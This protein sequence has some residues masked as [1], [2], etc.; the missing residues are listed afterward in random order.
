[1][2]TN[3]K[4]GYNGRFGN[5]LFQFASL[6]GIGNKMGFDVVIPKRN[7]TNVIKQRTMDGKE[8][9]AKFDLLDCFDIDSKYFSDNIFV[10]SV[11]TESHFHFD[12]KMFNIN[13]FTALDGYFQ[14]DKYFK[15]CREELLEI[16]KFR[17]DILE[18]SKSLLPKNEGKEL[19]SIHI[20]RGDYTTPNQ[21]HP[22]LGEDYINNALEYFRD[23]KYHFVVFSD[24]LDWCKRT[25][26]N[27]SDFTFF[28]SGSPYIDFCV[29][30]LCD[31]NI[32]TNSSFSW[33]A[34]YL[35]KIDGKKVIAPKKWFGPG[36]ANYIT[37]D[38]YP[39]WMI[40]VD[41]E[42]KK[43]LFEINIL[44]IC[45]GKY[46]SFFEGFYNSCEKYFLPNYK[47]NYF[48]FTDGDLIQKE[49]VNKIQQNK[50]GWP[51][52]TMMRF[53]MFNQI[54][55]QLKGEYTYF[56]N[57]NMMFVDFIND[58]VI[59]KADNDFL[60]GVNH[61][62]FF[63][64]STSDFPYERN[65]NSNFSI[66]Y[67]DGIRYYQGC[68]NGGKTEYFME[69]SSILE[70]KIDED[71]NGGII[72]IWHDE[73]ALNWYYSTKNPL[74]V[75]PSYAYPESWHVSMDKKILQL[76]KS[77]HGGHTFLRS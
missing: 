28:D 4:I 16:L 14:T 11:S 32:I 43:N 60:M 19:V 7:I 5:Q 25:W 51:F 26:G 50:L 21:Y 45:T 1:M 72:P 55:D 27:N 69:M 33:W 29:M 49:N 59:P 39:D 46:I 13:D 17:T 65:P 64:K 34:A 48:V 2:I 54:K 75:S 58:E 66:S 41:C 6:I 38:L 40:K 37:D 20:R 53:K 8:I 52:D 10:N 30:S 3:V 36:Y 9:S 23:S 35:S 76:D 74:V 57:V 56:F 68:F 31:H 62:G 24:D 15:H 22:V 42:S 63:D 67:G 77:K 71:V 70:K 12:E 44:T 18:K 61:P 47:K 73:S